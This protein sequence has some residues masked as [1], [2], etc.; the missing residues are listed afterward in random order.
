MSLNNAT[1]Y[2]GHLL[3][4]TLDDTSP[5]SSS[6]SR[7]RRGG[8]DS[9]VHSSYWTRQLMK[10]EEFDTHRLVRVNPYIMLV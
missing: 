5:S 8:D 6:R 3:S 4:D 10:A 7:K 9:P 1:F 2:R